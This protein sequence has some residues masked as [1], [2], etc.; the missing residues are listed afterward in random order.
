MPREYIRDANGRQIGFT[1]QSG[2]RTNVF[3]ATGHKLGY[4]DER[5]TFDANGHKILRDGAPATLIKRE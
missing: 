2:S 3:D 1:E 5:G 4:A